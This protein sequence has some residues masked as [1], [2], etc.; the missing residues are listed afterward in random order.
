MTLHS[1]DFSLQPDIQRLY[2][3]YGHGNST[4]HFSSLY[5]WRHEMELSVWLEPEL[6]AVK[7]AWRGEDSWFFP[8]GDT[9]AKIRFLR[10]V[11]AYPSPRLCYACPEDVDFCTQHVPGLYQFSHTPE[12]DEYLYDRAR[13]VA[14]TGKNFRHQRNALNRLSSSHMLSVR[15]LCRDTWNDA[16]HVLK[17]WSGI[18]HTV[19][20]GGLIGYHAL[21]ELL[22]SYDRLAVTGIV[23]YEKDVP[24]ALAAGYILTPDCFDLSACIQCAG[25]P[26]FAVFARHSLLQVLP[27]TIRTVNAEEDL[28]IIG[29]RTLKQGM[30]PCRII[31][32]YEGKML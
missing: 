1:L 29:L 14:L 10:S 22:R 25:N 32:T 7:A 23:V 27:C 3:Q 8:C 4:L 11:T 16:F 13:Q 12:D 30:S 31:P 9:K 6:F 18:R 2:R 26:D 21:E 20:A 17:N 28:G 24:C 15:M 19:S 5:V